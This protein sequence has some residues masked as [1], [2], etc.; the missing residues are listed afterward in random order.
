MNNSI[1][2]YTDY[3]SYLQTLIGAAPRAGHG[4]RKKLA[5]AMHIQPTYLSQV[6]NGQRDLSADQVVDLAQFLQLSP[7][8]TD[9]LLLLLS[10][11]R[12]GTRES[13]QYFDR[14][15]EARQ[16]AYL[17]VRKRVKINSSLDDQAKAVYYSDIAYAAVHMAITIPAL[18]TPLALAERLNISIERV[19][20]ITAFLGDQGLITSDG[21]HFLPSNKELFVDRSSPFI[22]S[23]HRNWRLK[24]IE[25]ASVRSLQ[26]YQVSLAVTLSEADAKR[27]RQKLA[28]FIEDVAK[29]I[30]NSP[31]EKLMG[32]AIDF[33][34]F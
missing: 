20:S 6:L 29:E 13:R 28:T 17:Q 32:L 27:V 16:A 3:R 9:Y 34:D 31:E 25:R 2:G 5:E 22:I 21:N 10:R 33:F 7:E 8:E 15:I 19:R 1:H 24:A 26:D 23:H 30:K 12:A 14:A 11:G 18:Q 4:Y